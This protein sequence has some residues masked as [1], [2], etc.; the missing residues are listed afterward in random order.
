LPRLKEGKVVAG[1]KKR[2]REFIE[3]WTFE[4][5]ISVDKKDSKLLM[6]QCPSCGAPIESIGQS[7]VCPYC[8]ALIH[9]D[10]FS[11]ILSTISQDEVYSLV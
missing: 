5:Q 4:R 6:R 1:S 10:E 7:Y 3:Y 8:G 2:L 11:W 9:T